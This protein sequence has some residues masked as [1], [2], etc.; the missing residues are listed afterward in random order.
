MVGGTEDPVEVGTP[1]VVV[2]T[3]AECRFAHVL[4]P[5]T[6]RRLRVL[7]N[8]AFTALRRAGLICLICGRRPA[9]A[10]IKTAHHGAK[11]V[12]GSGEYDAPLPFS[13]SSSCSLSVSLSYS[14]A[15]AD[16]FVRRN[17]HLLPAYGCRPAG[18]SSRCCGAGNA[19]LLA[20]LLKLLVVTVHRLPDRG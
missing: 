6:A 15:F 14:V 3:L 8:L 16:D 17:Q 11:L 4:H 9:K 19:A 7:L 13:H 2:L 18:V 10:G 5:A 20:N 12:A 1:S